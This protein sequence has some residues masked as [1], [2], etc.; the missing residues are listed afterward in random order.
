MSTKI[1]NG[2]ILKNDELFDSV[3]LLE[4]CLKH[5]KK[6]TKLKQKLGLK[7]LA[8]NFISALDS[9]YINGEQP[10]PID[11]LGNAWMEISERVREIS[12]S[13]RRDVE[14]D[15]EVTVCFIPIIS[16]K[17]E[18]KKMLALFYAENEEFTKCWESIKGVSEYHYQNQS[19]QPDELSKAEWR[20]R[21]KDWNQALPYNAAVPAMRGFVFKFCDDFFPFFEKDDLLKLVPPYEKRVEENSKRL[22]LDRKWQKHIEPMDENELKNHLWS[23]F[24]QFHDEHKK[25]R[26]E[27]EEGKQALEETR[28]EVAS[29]ILKEI[30]WETK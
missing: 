20:Q 8:D 22:L 7:V 14:V 30:T 26:S 19:D 4:F 25:W 16:G 28:Q 6:F 13:M 23:T 24:M 5:Q 17:D 21:E 2:Y 9:K 11:V 10:A 12:R 18:T 15:L 29:K 1:Y 27:T 3:K